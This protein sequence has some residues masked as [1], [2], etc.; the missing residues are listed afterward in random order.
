MFIFFF[1]SNTFS[2][3]FPG[4][5]PPLQILVLVEYIGIEKLTASLGFVQMAK[6]FSAVAGPPL[7]GK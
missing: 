3:I 4:Y 1:S 5:F 6:G 2:L 7:A